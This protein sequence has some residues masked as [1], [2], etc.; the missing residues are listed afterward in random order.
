MYDT[1][2]YTSKAGVV[3]RSEYKD[4]AGK[5]GQCSHKAGKAH[6]KNLGM[7]EQ[8]K[9]ANNRLKN[10]VF[11]QPV[12][13]AI[14]ATSALSTYKKGILTEEFLQ[15]SSTQRDVNHGVTIVGYGT[16]QNGDPAKIWCTEYWIVRNSWG[17]KWGEDGFFRLC[18]DNAGFS[19]AP[20]GTCLINKYI[21]FPTM[22]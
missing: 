19:K 11:R 4:Y 13:A 8:E 2:D 10:H 3:L 15:C 5:Q 9:V 22:Q 21:T 18:M 1:Y 14:Y 7:V 17:T 12:G 6:F 16:V 20:L